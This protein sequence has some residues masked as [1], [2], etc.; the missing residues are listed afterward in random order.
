MKPFTAFFLLIGLLFLIGCGTTIKHYDK[1]IN[2]YGYDFSKYSKQGFLFTP[3]KYLGEYESVGIL[4]VE[5]V[6]EA[7]YGYPDEGK[8]KGEFP[9][10]FYSPISATEL[11][12]SLYFIATGMGADAV[13]N[14]IIEDFKTEKSS[15]YIPSL[16]A[17][18]FAIKRKG[19]FK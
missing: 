16:R 2:V 13:V 12:D 1:E 4:S 15:I 14:L 10:W 6:P 19:E 18:G 8:K 11:L 17:S 3:E 7:N 9:R 5:I